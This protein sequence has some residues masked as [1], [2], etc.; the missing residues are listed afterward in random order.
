M[1]KARRMLSS[2]LVGSA[3]V[4]GLGLPQ[5]SV[6]N[7]SA[8][9]LRIVVGFPPG[10]A[11]DIVA[12]I[13]SEQL[14][15]RL[16]RTVLVENRP[17]AGGQI[18]TQALKNAPADGSTIM[19]TI[20]HSQII[21]PLTIAAAGYDPVEDFTPIGG[22]AQYYNALG[23][24]STIGVK[25]MEELKQWLIDNPDKANIGVP[26]YGSVPQ[27][28]VHI[29][30][31]NFDVPVSSVPYKGGAPLVQDLIG[32]HIP[33]AVASMTELIEHQRAGRVV[34]LA[35]SGQA[36]NNT[37]PEIPTFA[38]VGI[39]GLDRNPWLA[40]FGPK[41]LSPEFVA[42]FNKALAEVLAEPEI[43]ERLAEMGNEVTTTTSEELREWV[44]DGTK[45]WSGVIERAGFVPQ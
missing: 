1:N 33:G 3:V 34:I 21:V 40:F 19:L 45:H 10:G 4:A 36:R 32:G 22:V 44:V 27:F 29:I 35:T 6:A 26:A 5:A 12:R 25:N 9:P 39:E 31:E 14:K 15:D 41:G 23:V 17:G 37:M 7:E 42:Q 2:I 8:G 28:A 18:A 24:S 30:S 20:D 38:E 13:L 16:N 43:R 11:T